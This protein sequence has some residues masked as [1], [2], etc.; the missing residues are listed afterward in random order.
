MIGF[1]TIK[2][3]IFGLLVAIIAFIIPAIT[4]F[5]AKKGGENEIK[6]KNLEEDL[7][8]VI[9]SKKIHNHT[10]NMS[11]HEHIEFLHEFERKE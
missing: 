3:A 9:Q 2:T 4:A 11:R 1:E 8:S 7:K 6:T 5:F 10:A